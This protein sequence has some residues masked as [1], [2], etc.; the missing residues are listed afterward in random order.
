MITETLEA[1][2]ATYELGLSAGPWTVVFPKLTRQNNGCDC[3]V[4]VLLFAEETC[5]LPD[6]ET[7][8]TVAQHTAEYT[9]VEGRR[10]LRDKIIGAHEAN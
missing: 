3:G 1:V 2:A 4:H 8:L 6:G 5:Q 10:A 7:H 9:N